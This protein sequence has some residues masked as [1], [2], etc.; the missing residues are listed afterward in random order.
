MSIIADILLIAGA[1][2]AGLYCV[3]LSRRLSRFSDLENGVGGAIAALSK[4]VDEMTSALSGARDTAAS[5][6]AS[7]DTLTKR[8]D[9]VACRLELLVAAM[10]DLPDPGDPKAEQPQSTP[11]P[12]TGPD[13]TGD[14]VL[15]LSRRTRAEEPVG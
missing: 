5:S 2:G 6:T 11:G 13:D 14:G 4:H 7:L 15:F 8:A 3:V 9:G 10:H 12:K 1:F